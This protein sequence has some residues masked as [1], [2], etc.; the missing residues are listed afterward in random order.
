METAPTIRHL[1]TK[2]QHAARCGGRKGKQGAGRTACAPADGFL[3]HSFLPL[4][5][6][7]VA[8]K[9]PN[10]EW[11]FFASLDRV[12]QEYNLKAVDFTGKPYPYN[13][14]LAHT[15]AQQQLTAMGRG[16]TLSVEQDDKGDTCL[17]TTE[18]LYTGD[19]LYYIPVVPLYRL[20]KDKK[21]KQTAELLL[22]VCSY[23]YRHAGVPYYRNDYEYICN[24]LEYI[25]DWHTEIR[26]SEGDEYAQGILAELSTAKY[27]GD[28]M[29]RKLHSPYHLE[30]L[31]QR[32]DIYKPITEMEHE[33]LKAAK[34][35]CK[36]LQDYPDA[37]LFMHTEV[38][39]PEGYD[40]EV[41]RAQQ[42]ISFVAETEGA[43]YNQM[44]QMINEEFGNCGVTEMPTLTKHFDRNYLSDGATL[45]FERRAFALLEN[46]CYLLNNLP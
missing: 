38:N 6:Q 26:E 15:R 33:V 17:A 19:T 12:V 22:S 13:V 14:L 28:V 25:E 46:I 43:L 31:Q 44:E 11:D 39:D 42:Y 7:E 4:Y 32:I 37:N 3:R 29:Q 27:Y 20:L 40:D 5:G 9:E 8:P 21:K 36:L 45:D 41:V 35:A 18:R 34:K 30:Q 23:L 10:I 2:P 16:I 1:R 24:Q